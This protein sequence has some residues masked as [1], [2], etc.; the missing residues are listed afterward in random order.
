MDM[1]TSNSAV[2]LVR[3]GSERKIGVEVE[4]A[5]LS[6]DT[7][8]E[9]IARCLG[10]VVEHQ[11][12]HRF[13]IGT[14]GH[15]DWVVELDTAWAREIESGGD[16][17]ATVART[18]VP[19]EIVT[20]PIGEDDLHLLDD[21]L[22]CLARLGARGSRESMVGA[23]GIH[24]NP[25]EPAPETRLV[26]V[27]RAYAAVEAWLRHVSDLDLM[28]RILP[29]IDPW[30]A[31][32]VRDLLDPRARELTMAD[33]MELY[34]SHV[35]SRNYGLDLLPLFRH[36][37][38]VRVDR[39]LGDEHGIGARPTYHFRLPECRLDEPGWSLMT[40]WSKWL[41]VESVAAV[42]AL[43]DHVTRA[44]AAGDDPIEAAAQALK[45]LT[46]RKEF[47]CLVRS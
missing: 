16:L 45:S 31:P 4:F 13:N 6:E 46:E 40:E 19:I 37:D 35:R 47:A 26:P 21:L 22:K 5:G 29:F 1:Q 39:R 10:G 24:F 30:P 15:G 2:P 32:L 11:G 25:A 42:P 23:Y 14:A 12:A 3:F 43:L 28:R 36:L 8:A 7:T 33:G 44:V 34:L 27:M 20:A 18:V 38:R 9:Q 41:L 17:A